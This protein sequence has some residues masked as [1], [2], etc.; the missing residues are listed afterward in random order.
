MKRRLAIFVA[1]LGSLLL[2]ACFEKGQMNSVNKTDTTSTNLTI[3]CPGIAS[4]TAVLIVKG[5]LYLD[6]DLQ[7]R[8]F[9]VEDEGD[10]W[11]ITLLKVKDRDFNGGDPIAWVK[12]SDGVV[13]AIQ[14]AK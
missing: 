14:N 11:K 12:K 4:E 10:K 1:T 7:N 2:M 5:R 3:S 8:E 9:K 6:Y 13:E